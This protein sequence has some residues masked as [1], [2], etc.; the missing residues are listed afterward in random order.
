[1][2]SGSFECEVVN[3]LVWL[4]MHGYITPAIGDQI[5]TQAIE[6]AKSS[7]CR[8][9]LFDMR[10]AELG[11]SVANLYVRPGMAEAMGYDR[12]HK[13]AMLCAATDDKTDFLEMVSKN[14][15]FQ[16]RVFTD[17]AECV[18]WLTS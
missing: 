8:L 12:T 18:A 3:G 1:M 10:D 7:D 9:M 2:N 16:F 6:T 11:E 5:M 14:R 13:S 4:R 15:G 17:E